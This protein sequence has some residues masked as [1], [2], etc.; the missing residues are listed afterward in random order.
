M[1]KKGSRRSSIFR[2]SR[3]FEVAH[4]AVV[5]NPVFAHQLLL[6]QSKASKK[7]WNSG[8]SGNAPQGRT[9][10][11]SISTAPSPRT[12]SKRDSHHQGTPLS[13]RQPVRQPP[14]P[15]SKLFKNKSEDG[16]PEIPTLSFKK[17]PREASLVSFGEFLPSLDTDADRVKRRLVGQLSF[18]RMHAQ[19]QLDDRSPF[20]SPRFSKPKVLLTTARARGRSQSEPLYYKPQILSRL[21]E[22]K[23]V[24]RYV[25]AEVR[26]KEES[27][28]RV[29]TG[30]TLREL[31]KRVCPVNGITEKRFLEFMIF[32]H[33]QFTTSSALLDLLSERFEEVGDQSYQVALVVR[34]RIINFIKLW[35]QLA[36]RDFESDPLHTCFEMFLN[37]L[38]ACENEGGS[39]SE[40]LQRVYEEAKLGP[41]ILQH[42]QQPRSPVIPHTPSLRVR[43]IDCGE[44]AR[45][46][47]LID[48]SIFRQIDH[49][50]LLHKSWMKKEK[51][52]RAPNV[53]KLIERFNNIS[54]WVTSEI[55]L[56]QNLKS[57]TSVL[58]YFIQLAEELQLIGN[59]HSL[60]AVYASLNN[61]CVQRMKLTW[62]EVKSKYINILK[63]IDD[64][65]S[66]KDNYKRYRLRLSLT[67]PPAIPFIGSYLSDLTFIEENEDCEEGGIIN[68]EKM[69]M[70]GKILV[71]V[72]S[73][74]LVP[75]EFTP[76][77]SV[78]EYLMNLRILSEKER[79][80]YSKAVEP[81]GKA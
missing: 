6:Q 67:A 12:T 70:L 69:R 77:P 48:F 24:L 22:S 74:Q 10:A 81:G 58:C 32:T 56:E 42:R 55:V 29:L 17:S 19:T 73:L 46:M 40:M 27:G 62:K 45:Q 80:Q 16:K 44:L 2:K 65:M 30:A 51:E 66:C 5:T 64:L 9:R 59:F 1:S 57:R 41:A 52:I 71:E 8:V 31:I 61:I 78:Q 15:K 18:G 28:E 13:A 35:I 39:W 75:Y 14:L 26:Y 43:D 60:M 4:E 25:N 68:W 33:K 54:Y 3:K 7:V 50:E 47:S 53:L 11:G 21:I 49:S 23:R 63:K 20:A 79:Y 72:H 36:I 34:L 76:V 37:R 38:Y